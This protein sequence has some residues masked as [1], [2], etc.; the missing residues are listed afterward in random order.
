MHVGDSHTLRFTFDAEKVRAFALLTGDDNP[1]H[2]DP[3]FAATTRFG[4]TIV[5]GAFVASLISRGLGA[6]FPGR[7]TI[8][9]AQEVQFLAPVFTDDTVDV[10]F[11]V[12]AVDERGRAVLDTHVY[13]ADGTQVVAGRATVLIPKELRS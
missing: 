4:R 12:T 2:T 9:I 10:R 11:V 6:E 13:K 8:Y 7:G 5:H 1:I 3:A